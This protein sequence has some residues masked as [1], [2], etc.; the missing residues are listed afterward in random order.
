MNIIIPI[1][2]IGERFKKEG[3]LFPKPLIKILGKEVIFWLID[4]LNHQLIEHI[5]IPY[6]NEL[7]Q[8]NF[9][10]LLKKK[11]PKLNFIFHILEKQT[12]G[13]AETLLRQIEYLEKTGKNTLLKNNTICLDCDNFY[14]IDII[15]L[16]LNSEVKNVVFNFRDVQSD[17]IFSYVKVEGEKIVDIVEKE[18][19]SDLANTG[20]YCFENL[21]LLKKYCQELIANQD[22]VKN[23]YYTSS[24][25]KRMLNDNINFISIQIPKDC[26]ISLGTPLQAKIFMNNIPKHTAFTKEN[27]I[28]I[29]TMRFC[30]DLDNTLVTFP[31]VDGDYSSVEPLERNIAILRYLKKM[32]HY[33]I[34][35][36]ARRMRTHK[37]NMG[38][39]LAD[40][41]KIT[42]ETLDKFEIPYDEI[43]FGK[44]EAD[45]YIDDKAVNSLLS[46]E[47]EIGFFEQKLI[48]PRYFNQLEKSSIETIIKK[49]ESNKLKGEIYW[50]S[51]MPNK[52]KD[53][54]PLLLRY[55][56]NWYEME[57]ISG[58]TISHLYLQEELKEDTLFH[59]LGS[60]KRI[61]NS[62]DLKTTDK[63]IYENYS[64][65]LVE[66]YQNFDYSGIEGSESIYEVFKKFFKK[67]EEEDGAKVGVIHGDPVFTNIIL[68]QF[69][70]LKFI[71]MRGILMNE[72]SMLGDIFYDYAKIYQSLLGYDEKIMGKQ[73]NKY[74]KQKMIRY[75]EDYIVK[76]FDEKTLKNIKIITYS[77]I[78]TLIP[79]HF[80][81]NHYP[82]L[83]DLLKDHSYLL[84][85][86]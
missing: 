73:I 77:L 54:F 61:H 55:G 52:I 36:T 80:G 23:E 37:G 84:S 39:L 69:N 26:F 15:N 30:F 9:E 45:F 76:E 74:Y 24:V 3:Y 50:Y 4:N 43:Y 65:K 16:Y 62:M 47:K 25:I 38:R 41:G 75:F 79:L 59:I 6:N 48:E 5:L 27:E 22:K 68:N 42:F 17:P 35:H 78:F 14:N 58:I 18:K 33:I 29:D 56:D 21:D 60:V 2:G 81:E 86:Q 8:Y 7:A 44:P 63:K 71:D 11:Y 66:R 67:Y 40:I 31:K 49:S 13:A 51:N 70:K 57:K 28:V 12:E 83:L 82:R 34:I 20:C 46:V 85:N 32:G 72:E 53:I 10:D 64:R 19:I 1:G